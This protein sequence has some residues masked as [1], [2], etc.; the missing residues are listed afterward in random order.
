MRNS[1]FIAYPVDEQGSALS[2]HVL[3][4]PF[5]LNHL[6]EPEQHPDTDS[7][8][9]RLVS[10]FEPGDYYIEV[11]HAGGPYGN[12][13]WTLVIEQPGVPTSGAALPLSVEGVDTGVIGP[14][15][16]DGPVRVTLETLEPRL[17]T[18]GDP[19]TFNYFVWMTD[20]VG[21]TRERHINSLGPAPESL[22]AVWF[23]DA[24]TDVVFFNVQSFGAWRATVE[25]V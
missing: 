23:P 25:A 24:E 11:S 7:Y 12:G 13:D 2:E 8:T 17:D 1:N 19:S 15:V 14:V 10:F 5:H 16:V 22:S 9:A 4:H 21:A 20:E 6:F 3:G 18:D